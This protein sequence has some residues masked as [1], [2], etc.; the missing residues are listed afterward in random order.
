MLALLLA[1]L[2]TLLS[3]WLTDAMASLSRP[4]SLCCNAKEICVEANFASGAGTYAML[5]DTARWL[6]F[7]ARVC[8]SPHLVFVGL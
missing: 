2:L 8:D 1:R 7:D 4:L 6:Q 5:V 3:G